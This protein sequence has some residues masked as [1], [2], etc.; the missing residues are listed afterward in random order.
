LAALAALLVDVFALLVD[1]SDL[2]V[3]DFAL[4]VDGLVFLLVDD[5]GAD[6]SADDPSDDVTSSWEAECFPL[7]AGWVAG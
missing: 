4:L 6:S 3:D 7:R 1:G 5:F 2:L